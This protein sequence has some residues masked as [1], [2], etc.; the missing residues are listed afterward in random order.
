MAIKAEATAIIFALNQLAPEIFTVVVSEV[1]EVEV[2]TVTVL[3]TGLEVG[4][5]AINVSYPP[6]AIVRVVIGEAFTTF[7]QYIKPLP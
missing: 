6:V 5:Q 7:L 1:V 4:L 2:V 3:V